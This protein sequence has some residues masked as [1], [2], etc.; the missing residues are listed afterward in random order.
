MI[1]DITVCK[2]TTETNKKKYLKKKNT[3][4][5]NRIIMFITMVSFMANENDFL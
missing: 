5:R 3:F 1:K 4:Y 2:K